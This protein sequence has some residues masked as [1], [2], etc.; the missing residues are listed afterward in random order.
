MFRTQHF[1]LSLVL[2]LAFLALVSRN[3]PQVNAQPEPLAVTATDGNY[4]AILKSI[5]VATR[6]MVYDP[7][8]NV[9]YASTPSGAGP[10]LGNSVV[11][12]GVPTLALGPA[13][14]VGSEP[15][16][17]AVS[18]NGQFVYA[19][20]DG[21]GAVRRVN[22]PAQTADLQFSLGSAPFSCGKMMVE[23]MLVLKGS[24]RAVVIARRNSSCS[25]RH[26]G[27]IIYDDDVPRPQTTPGHTGSNVIQPS[28]S[29]S[30]LY[31]YN[32]FTTEF[33]FRVMTVNASGVTVASVTRGLINMGGSTNIRYGDGLIYA[34]TGAVIDTATLTLVGSYNAAGSVY[35]DPENGRVYFLST[36]QSPVQLKIF[37]LETFLPLATFNLT[38]VPGTATDLTGAG[39]G[40]LAF[41]TPARVYLMNI[42]ELDKFVYL[43]AVSHNYCSDF[44]DDFSNPASGWEVAEDGTSRREYLNGEYRVLSKMPGHFSYFEAPTCPRRNYTVELDARWEGTPG[45]HYGMLFG[46]T[47]DL[48]QYYY[49]EVNSESGQ[50][51]LLRSTATGGWVTIVPLQPSAAI[52]PGNQ[53]NHLRATR[54]GNNISLAI[55]GT[56]LGNWTDSA[57]TGPTGVALMASLMP[58][59][60]VSDARFDNFR[61]TGLPAP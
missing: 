48:Q 34:T 8:A 60:P 43:P 4:V 57:I 28:S 58:G 24:P 27:V 3:Q 38:G 25:P 56:L 33:G 51:R 61:V 10:A 41:R 47:A 29:P 2:M 12:I 22:V 19:G 5:E 49:F 59:K 44:F 52:K 37:D 53:S 30:T 6:H 18:D 35:P 54:N 39:D 21:A 42:A 14:F 55:N 17:V 31:G 32:N 1:V 20:L 16:K 26:E 36:W 23:D 13:I 50:F 9:L 46:M 40:L 45:G 15:N 11:S 7:L